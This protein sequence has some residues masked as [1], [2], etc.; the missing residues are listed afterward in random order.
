MALYFLLYRHPYPYDVN[1]CNMLA[2]D[3]AIIEFFGKASHAG[4]KPW[5][6]INAL[7][8]FMQGWNNMSMLRQQ[9]LTTNRLG[10]SDFIGL[11]DL[12]DMDY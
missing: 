11:P 8:A 6:G 10:N 9:T 5:E 2:L 3:I 1:Y 4:M 12:C 7:D